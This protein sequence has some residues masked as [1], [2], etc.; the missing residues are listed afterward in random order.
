MN[1]IK[2]TRIRSIVLALTIPLVLLFF[3]AD[4]DCAKGSQKSSDELLLEI[5]D[6]HS[7]L[8]T[9]E[10]FLAQ[11]KML[12]AYLEAAHPLE[13]TKKNKI[14]TKVLDILVK[15]KS[16]EVRIRVKSSQKEDEVEQKKFDGE[17]A[18]KSVYEPGAALLEI[19]KVDLESGTTSDLPVIRTYWKRDLDYSGDFILPDRVS[20]LGRNS[21]YVAKFSFYYHA[22]QSGKYGFT[23]V[24]DPVIRCKLEVGGFTI[25]EVKEGRTRGEVMSQGTC[26]LKKGFH[27]V[28][29]WLASW[30]SYAY[31]KPG[32][33]QVKVLTPRGFDAVPITKDMMLLKKE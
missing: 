30:T 15:I 25:L 22:E 6:L 29:F 17:Q 1:L 2:T 16:S 23:V 5:M 11:A 13:E 10:V 24:R 32:T 27:R 3:G 26:N 9:N 8:V 31:Q 28:E 21:P 33:F 19:F 18:D 14:Y 12:G 4:P 7:E 20:E